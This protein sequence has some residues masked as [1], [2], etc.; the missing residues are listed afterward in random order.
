MRIL[1]KVD[2]AYNFKPIFCWVC[3]KIL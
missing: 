3:L 1:W 2:H